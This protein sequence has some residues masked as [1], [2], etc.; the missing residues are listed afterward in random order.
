L[1]AE[2]GGSW[3]SRGG[4][5]AEIKRER[6]DREIRSSELQRDREIRL[7]EIENPKNK[8]QK[9]FWP[10]YSYRPEQAETG[11]TGQNGPKF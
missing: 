2:A 11:E 1:K 8:T 3:W 10:D 7:G 6:R 4:G 5:L 9:V